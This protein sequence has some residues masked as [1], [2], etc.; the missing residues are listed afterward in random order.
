M[1]NI[2]FAL[3]LSRYDDG[4]AMF[5]AKT[6]AGTADIMLAPLV[7]MVVLVIREA[8]RIENQ[9]ILNVILVYVGGQ[10]K[11]IFAAQD[12]YCK[13]HADFMGLLRRVLPR[14]KGLDQVAAQVRSLVDGVAA[15]PGKFNVRGF[16]GAAIGGYKQLSVRLFRVADI[17]NGCFQR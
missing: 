17:V 16:G 8:D 15:S 9:V 13:L 1:F 7:G 2:A 14:L 12:F 4:Q 5:F 3:V 10:D 6:V 11:F